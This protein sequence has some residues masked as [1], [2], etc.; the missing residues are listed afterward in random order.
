MIGRHAPGN[1]ITINNIGLTKVQT[2]YIS[3]AMWVNKNYQSEEVNLK[4]RLACNINL[5][6]SWYMND[7]YPRALE[8][9]IT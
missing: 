5:F 2:L 3:S 1:S 8:K 6:Y 9:C 7:E 4:F